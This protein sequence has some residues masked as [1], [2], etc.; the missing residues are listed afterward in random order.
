MREA[1][2]LILH[3]ECHLTL[4][5]QIIPGTDTNADMQYMQ[6]MLHLAGPGWAT[7]IPGDCPGR[8]SQGGLGPL[9]D[10]LGMEVQG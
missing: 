6:N 3:A 9:S 5:C 10:S 4:F 8:G 1:R 7:R 2:E